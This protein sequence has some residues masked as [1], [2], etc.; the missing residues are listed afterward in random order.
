MIRKEEAVY[1]MTKREKKEQKNW[2]GDTEG[3]RAVQFS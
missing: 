1:L 2:I 3:R